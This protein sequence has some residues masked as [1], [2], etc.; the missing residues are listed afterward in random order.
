ML[1]LHYFGHLMRRTDS[2]ENTPM[3]EKM[4]GKRRRGQQGMRWLDSITGSMGTSLSKLQEKVKGRED[5]CATVH[6]LEELD[7]T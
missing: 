6:G 2:L 1:M 7:T 5:C 3:L 4:K